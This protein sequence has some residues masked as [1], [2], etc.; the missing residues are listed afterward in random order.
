MMLPCYVYHQLTLKPSVITPVNPLRRG[1]QKRRN[2]WAQNFVLV[3]CNGT[4]NRVL[5]VTGSSFSLFLIVFKIFLTITIGLQCHVP[6]IH[7]LIRQENEGQKTWCYSTTNC[8]DSVP[9]TRLSSFPKYNYFSLHHSVFCL[10][11][12]NTVTEHVDLA[13]NCVEGAGAYYLADMLKENMFIVYLVM[14]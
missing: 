11:Q 10:L 2:F 5:G 7:N 6:S 13:D 3:E 14:F 4:T 8:S 9:P 12:R 1:V